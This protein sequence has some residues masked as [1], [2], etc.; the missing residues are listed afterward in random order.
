MRFLSC[1][2]V[3]S[4]THAAVTQNEETIICCSIPVDTS[5]SIAHYILYILTDFA[6]QSKKSV[7]HMSSL[8]HSFV[9]VK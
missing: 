9:L 4:L 2:I 3:G 1:L 5:Q 8:F 6:D 7:I